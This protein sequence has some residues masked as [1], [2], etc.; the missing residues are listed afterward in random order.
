LEKSTF[1]QDCRRD[2]RGW[3]EW[4][5]VRTGKVKDVRVKCGENNVTRYNVVGPMRRIL[6][7]GMNSFIYSFFVG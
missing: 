6:P 7:D 4:Q 2:K 3:G 1:T 5:G